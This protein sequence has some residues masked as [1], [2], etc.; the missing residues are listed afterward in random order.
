MINYDIGRK[1]RG[2]IKH[3]EFVF[4]ISQD[5]LPIFLAET[6]DHLQILD[7]GLIRLEHQE[8]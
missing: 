2:E 8:V 5:E 1:D 7:E 6:E 3:M 4:D